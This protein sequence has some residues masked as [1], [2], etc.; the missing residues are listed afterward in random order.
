MDAKRKEKIED[1]LRYTGF[2][3][4]A[5]SAAMSVVA[6]VRDVIHKRK[7]KKLQEQVKAMQNR[8]A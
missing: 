3:L 5:I 8:G 1:T 6:L 2:G 7:I 4:I